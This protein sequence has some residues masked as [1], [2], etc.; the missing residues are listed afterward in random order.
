M[1]LCVIPARGGSKRI[2]RKNIRLFNGKPIISRSID[3]ALRANCF[4]R[5]IVSTDD[6]EIAQI[7]I[8]YGAEVPFIRPADLSDDYTDTRSVVEHAINHSSVCDKS[9]ESVCCLYATAPFVQSSHLVEAL[10]LLLSSRQPTTVFPVTTF[11][12]PIQ[13]ALRLGEDGFCSMV[14]SLSANKRSQDLEEVVHDA[15][16]FYWASPDTW[17]KDRNMFDGGKPLLIPRW[18][19]ND[20]DTEEDWVRAELIY[21]ALFAN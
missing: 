2:I 1:N 19:V 16:Q 17:R 6:N 4:D 20:I 10:N 7:A 13:Q 9:Y 11:P 21:K 3:I 12:Y 14:N 8:Q 5:I 18:Y 15:G